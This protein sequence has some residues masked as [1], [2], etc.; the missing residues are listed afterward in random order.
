MPDGEQPADQPA[1]QTASSN[2]A[3]TK[4]VK[5]KKD[6]VPELDGTKIHVK[7]FSPYKVYFDDDAKS[8]SAEND[9]GP[10]DILPRHHNFITLVNEC[11]ILINTLEDKEKRIRITKAVMHVRHNNVTVFLDV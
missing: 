6:E 10:F 9:T 3:K 4:L 7:L 11:E 8:I 5:S 1:E 2:P